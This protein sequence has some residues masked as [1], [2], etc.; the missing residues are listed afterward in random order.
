MKKNCCYKYVLNNL[1]N[2]YYFV[3]DGGTRG[4]VL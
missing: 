1:F 4:V 3:K 2:V